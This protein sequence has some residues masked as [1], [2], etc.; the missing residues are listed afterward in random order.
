MTPWSAVCTYTSS[1]PVLPS[2]ALF[3]R[4]DDELELEDGPLDVIHRRHDV[5]PGLGAS[6]ATQAVTRILC[7][8][9]TAS[10]PCGAGVAQPPGLTT[11]D[12]APRRSSNGGA[13]S[14]ARAI[15]PCVIRTRHD[16]P[17]AV[18]SDGTYARRGPVITASGRGRLPPS[19]SAILVP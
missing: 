1:R 17:Q 7:L 6:A 5:Y 4:D 2:L 19:L 18:L 14:H 12:T 16:I 13:F 3:L 10:V 11:P 15:I 8:T 9:R